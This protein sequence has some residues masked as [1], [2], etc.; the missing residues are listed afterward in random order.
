MGQC[1]TQESA[2]ALESGARLVDPG[3]IAQHGEE[4][5]RMRIVRGDLDTRQ[6]D[7]AHAGILD[8]EPDEFGDRAGSAPRGARPGE[9]RNA[10]DVGPRASTP[11]Q[12][13]RATSTISYVSI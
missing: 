11:A 8:L 9:R 4:H 13:E 10:G 5:L 1:R 6:G 3:E 7:E 2:G 12:S